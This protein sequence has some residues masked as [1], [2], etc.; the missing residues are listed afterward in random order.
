MN[1]DLACHLIDD[2]LENRLS[3]RD[4]HRLEEHLSRCS[5]CAEELHR[6]PAFERDVKQALATSVRSLYL[7]PAVSTRVIQAA[8]NSFCRGVWL[9]GVGMALRVT[10]STVIIALLL[11]GLFSLLGHI[12]VPSQLR[13]ITLLPASKLSLSEQHPVTLSTGNQPVPRSTAASTVLL[14]NG[15]L[16]IEPL[17]LHPGKP[18]TMTVFLHSDLPRPLDT[19][20]L[21]LDISGPERYYHFA[22]AVKGPLPTH[23]ISI[24]RITPDLLASLCHE[25]YLIPSTDIFGVPGVYTVRVV[26]FNPVVAPK[27]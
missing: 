23:G 10:A 13:P 14:A 8:Q 4:H 18:F 19:V 16:L 7:S 21:D 5:R 24:V 11:V 12:P 2:Y 27:R 15:D 22:L 17:D 3:Q 25:Q 9:N 20:H 26:L 1:C 6:R